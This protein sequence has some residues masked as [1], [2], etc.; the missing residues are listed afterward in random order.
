MPVGLD[1]ATEAAIL[2]ATTAA[3]H[4]VGIENGFANTDLILTPDGP[5]VLEVNGRIGG[6]IH[7]LLAMIGVPDLIRSAMEFALGA[8]IEIAQPDPGRVAF[9]A[10]HQPPLDAVK[11]VDLAGVEEVEQ[12]PGVSRV[13][14]HR[15]PGDA[16]DWR[17]G[18]QSRVLTVYGVVADRDELYERHQQIDRCIDAQYETGDPD[19]A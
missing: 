15:H 17:L 18:T 1:A 6:E 10:Y 14:R 11:L 4:A 3:I 5:R 13:V 19:G 16:V 8:E 9:C 12:L 7:R 2:D